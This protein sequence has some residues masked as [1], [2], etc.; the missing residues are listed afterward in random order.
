MLDK[1]LETAV[2]LARKAGDAVMKYYAL[3]IVAEQKIGIDNFSEPVTEAD[4]EASRI[5]V[6]GLFEAFPKDAILSEEE[7]DRMERRLSKDRVW[8][9][10]PIDGTAGFIK[11]DG[12]FAVQIGLAEHGEAVL[13]AV[14]MPATDIL[15]YAARGEGSYK[16]V[17]GG[18]PEELHVSDKTDFREMNLAVSRNHRSPKM[19]QIVR[20]FGLRNEIQRGSVGIKVGLI[21]EQVCDLYIHLSPRTKFWDT[22][23]PQV[24]LEEAGGKLT[25]LFGDKIRYNIGDVQNLNGILASNGASHELAVNA[26]K[27]ILREF[28]R[29]KVTAAGKR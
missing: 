1:E 18:P 24:I 15:Y 20:D 7:I 11:M 25:D 23:G 14:Y 4:R 6:Q 27:P 21:T 10:D 16:S 2:A 28:G 9:V 19:S 17:K 12:D 8:I 13:G 3:E 29:V 26:L 5:I 22:C